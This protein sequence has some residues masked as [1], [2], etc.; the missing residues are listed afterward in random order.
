MDQISKSATPWFSL[1]PRSGGS[2]R[3]G[4][5]GQQPQ[6]E[7]LDGTESHVA[8]ATRSQLQRALRSRM[9]PRLIAAFVKQLRRV[10]DEQ[11]AVLALL[12]SSPEWALPVLN[13]QF[14]ALRNTG[15][16][17]GLSNLV[18]IAGRAEVLANLLDAKVLPRTEAHGRIL[19]QTHGLLERLLEHLATGGSDQSCYPIAQ[20]AAH[21]YERLEPV[22]TDYEPGALKRNPRLH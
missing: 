7:E 17:L 6:E 14:F 12:D 1:R 22:S 3:S 10:L 11:T 4:T 20:T 8:S 5:A 18:A 13:R 15:D 21:L 19:R 16:M 2:E 9:R